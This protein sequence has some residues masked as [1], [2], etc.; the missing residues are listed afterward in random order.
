M[1]SAAQIEVRP[2]TTGEILDDAWRL[3]LANAP[4]LLALSSLFTAPIFM[5]LIWLLTRQAPSEGLGQLVWPAVAAILL[6]L[7]GLGSGAC[8]EVFR[9]G[10]EGITPNLGGCLIASFQQAGNHA[11]ACALLSALFFMGSWLLLLPGLAV[12]ISAVSVHPILAA[13][14]RRIFAALRAS[15]QE[16]QRQPVKAGA[17]VLSRFPLLLLAVVN[18]YLLVRLGLWTAEHLAGFDVALT[19]LLL[20]VDNPVYLSA[21]VM[22]AWLLLAPYFEAANYLVHVDA[23]VRYEGLDLWYR[24][25]RF[26]PLDDRRRAGVFLLAAGAALLA[27]ISGSA[28][29]AKLSAVEAARREVHSIAGEI[30]R[31]E[32]YPGSERWNARLR[33]IV[34]RLDR[35][36]PAGKSRYRWFHRAIEGFGHRGRESALKVLT[37]LDLRLGLIEESFRRPGQPAQEDQD[38]LSNE[39]LKRLLPPDNIHSKP[40]L[41]CGKRNSRFSKIDSLSASSEP[42]PKSDT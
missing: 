17:V 13:G 31:A 16:A 25:Q 15:S 5:A 19:A 38:A 30:A 20:S 41:P 18:L 29:D 27:A 23:R 9:R 37:D 12:L 33:A 1:A 11:A 32:P 40:A 3:Y 26:F 21:L 7:A 10:A 8:Q 36:S 35:D 39:D 34:T 2:R 6:P 24:V 4:L 22:L 42:T 14:E 28:N